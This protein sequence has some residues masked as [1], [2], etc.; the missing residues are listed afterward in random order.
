VLSNI[1]RGISVSRVSRKREIHR[2]K[3][4]YWSGEVTRE[5]NAMDLEDKVFMSRSAR[6]IAA[7]LKHSAEASRR[8]KAP[9]FQSAMSMLNFYINRAGHNLPASRRIILQRA[10]GEL[11]KIFGRT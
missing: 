5:S 8:R 10:K 1:S 7:S 11:R 9:A 6:H 4:G 3:H 2:G